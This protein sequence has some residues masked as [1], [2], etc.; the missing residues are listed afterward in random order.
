MAI[1]ITQALPGN[2]KTLLAAELL[3]KLLR[4]NIHQFEN[5]I[6]KERRR[7]A[8]NIVVNPELK[9]EFSDYI[10]EWDGLDD[11]VKLRGADVI[12]DDMG[13]VLDAQRW[14]DV[15]EDTKRWFRWHEHYGCDVYGNCQEFKDLANVVR[16]LTVSL[17]HL[18]K[19]MGSR[20]PHPTRPPVK[21][22]WGIIL[23]RPMKIDTSERPMDERHYEHVFTYRLKMIRKK[24][25]DVYDTTQD[26]KELNYPPLIHVERECGHCSK[27]VVKHI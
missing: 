12:F 25:C 23:S 22:P 20:R 26:M 19:I 1:F 17:T 24:Y 13:T 2:G 9:R 14:A 10:V 4:R 18:N 16:K 6:V 27:L 5:G 3:I 21:K 7:V 11:L 8:A 15:P